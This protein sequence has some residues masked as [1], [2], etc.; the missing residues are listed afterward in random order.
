MWPAVLSGPGLRSIHKKNGDDRLK[1]IVLPV[2]V[3]VMAW[4]AA[5]LAQESMIDSLSHVSADSNF[6]TYVE[7]GANASLTLSQDGTDK[8]AGFDSSLVVNVKIDSLHPWGSFGQLAWNAQTGQ[9]LDWS[10]S[11]TLR[12]WLKVVT[13]PNYPQNMAMRIQ[14]WDIDQPGDPKEVYI[15]ENDTIFAKARDWYQ[16]NVPLH[17][18][19]SDGS[20]SPGDSGFVVGPTSWNAFTYNNYKLDLNRIVGWN[21]VFVTVGTPPAGFTNIPLDTMQVKL[22]GFDRTGNLPIPFVI[23]NGITSPSNLGQAWTWG[24][25]QVFQENGNGPF[26]NTNSMHW[27]MGD[28]WSN[29]WNGWGYNVNPPYNLSGGWPVDSLKFYMKADTGV[30]SM[31]V[32][33][34]DGNAKVRYPFYVTQDTLW[35]QY[36]IPLRDITWRQDSNPGVFNPANVAVWQIMSEGDGKAGKNVWLSDVWTGNPPHP[37]PPVAATGVAVTKTPNYSNIVS[38]TDVPGQAGA[39]YNIYYSTS[40]ITNIDSANVA[41]TGV[42]QG[43]MSFTHVLT[44]PLTDQPVT[45]YY[46]VVCRSTDGLLGT[47]AS[48]NSAVTNTAKGVSVIYPLWTSGSSFNFKADGDL[49][50]WTNAGIKPFHLA[51][52]DGSGTK[53][54]GA[55]ISSDSVSSGDVYVA[56][57][58]TYLYVAGHINTNNIVFNASQSSWLNTSTDMFIGLYNYQG[59]PHTALEGGAQPDYHFR[60]AQ[61]RIIIDNKGT[62]SLEVP[63]TDYYWGARLVPDPLDGYNFEARIPWTDIAHKRNGGY[64]GTDSVF[65]PHVGARIPFDIELSSVSPGKTSRDGQLDYSPIADGNSY[66][67]VSVWSYTWIGDKMVMGVKQNVQT[68]TT[69]ELSQNYPNPFN[70]TTQIR[71]TIMKPGLVTLSVYNVLGQKVE[72]LVDRVQTAGSYTVTFDATKYASGV[73]FYQVKSGSFQNVKKMMLIK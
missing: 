28:Q 10:S 57:D 69:Y 49:S 73:Y 54:T 65:V 4:S 52:S 23:F 60:F 30:D 5:A 72:T 67:N 71:Y 1:K 46:A 3:A 32:Q 64:T 38:W 56:M 50:E 20:V 25:A 41:G 21:I 59:A 2:I 36:A 47:P 31:A 62:D 11:D 29:G 27:I 68:P 39:T 14:L 63:G 43:T 53:V 13:A 7:P 34:E 17:Q 70:P 19:K 33:F 55:I 48:Y 51:V 16:L 45:Y 37:V 15:Y 26:P 58:Q 40:P 22:A 9:Y 6:S 42:P 61:D 24:N 12:L 66:Q 8:P 44:A 18:I 35:H